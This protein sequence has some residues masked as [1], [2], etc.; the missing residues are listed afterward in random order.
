[1]AGFVDRAVEYLAV[2]AFIFFVTAEKLTAC[3]VLIFQRGDLRVLPGLAH[4]LFTP[5]ELIGISAIPGAPT[6]P[7]QQWQRDD[8]YE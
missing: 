4:L 5:T 8:G 7:L 2:T 1:M 6:T 3:A